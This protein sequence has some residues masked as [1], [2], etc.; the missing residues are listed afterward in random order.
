MEGQAAVQHCLNIGT[1][2]TG[3]YVHTLVTDDDSTV[4]ANTKHS[5]KA[6][7][8]RDYPGYTRK[9]GPSTWTT[10]MTHQSLCFE[11]TKAYYLCTVLH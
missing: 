9:A 2:P 4:R 1:Q 11:K 8:Q 10:P 3:V 6:I 5:Y 7:A